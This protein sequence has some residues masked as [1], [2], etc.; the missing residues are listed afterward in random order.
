VRGDGVGSV[1]SGEDMPLRPIA[2]VGAS[3]H[4]EKGRGR[5]TTV[6]LASLPPT[7]IARHGGH[8]LLAPPCRCC[9]D[10]PPIKCGLPDALRTERAP[11]LRSST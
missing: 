11:L 8:E 1:H 6:S 9:S 10:S 7:A 5:S 4:F 3:L 2:A